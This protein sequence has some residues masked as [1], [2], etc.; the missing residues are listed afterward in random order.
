LDPTFSSG[1]FYKNGVPEP[2]MKFDIQPQQE[3]VTEGDCCSLP[4]PSD[5]LRSIVFDPPFVGGSRKDGKPGIIKT[6]FSYFSSVPRLWEFYAEAL[7]EFHRILQ[8]EGI[9]VFKCQ[10][11]VESSKQYIS[12]VAVMNM[13]VSMGF[14]PK[15]LFIL[16]ATT[17]IISPNQWNQSHAR[18]YHS[19]FWVF[20][21]SSKFNV[22]YPICSPSVDSEV[23]N[24]PPCPDTPT[25]GMLS[26]TAPDKP[27]PEPS[28]HPTEDF[29]AWLSRIRKNI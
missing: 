2:R 3:D 9:L 20:E 28:T 17:R 10:D 24:A 16:T 22:R 19:Y 11:S 29:T 14:Y 15:D 12:H 8:P 7:H 23:S 5:C 26:L 4:L 25:T 27:P 21:K 13:A 1:V 18:K 6:R